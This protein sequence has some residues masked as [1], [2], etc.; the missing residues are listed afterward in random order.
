LKYPNCFQITWVL[1]MLSHA[2]GG[3]VD[4]IIDWIQYF[5]AYIALPC[6][7]LYSWLAWLPKSYHLCFPL[8]PCKV[9]GGLW[10]EIPTES[11]CQKITV[12]SSIELTIWDMVFP[13]YTL[14]TY[15]LL[16]TIPTNSYRSVLEPGQQICLKCNE[17]SDICSLPSCCFVHICYRVFTVTNE[18]HKTIEC[19]HKEK[20]AAT[21]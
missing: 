13:N 9:L 7:R 18:N 4:N 5:S 11:I 12:W 8:S 16:Q 20:R 14:G 10:L 21:Q 1:Q 6:P 15:Q 2:K 19:P 3:E 17:N